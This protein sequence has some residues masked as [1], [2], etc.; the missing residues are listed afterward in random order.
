MLVISFHLP[1][2]PV[3]LGHLK[4][5]QTLEGGGG[6]ITSVDFDPSVSGLC[7]S[8]V[9]CPPLSTPGRRG[10]WHLREHRGCPRSRPWSSYPNP[11]WATSSS[12]CLLPWAVGSSEAAPAPALRPEGRC[13]W[14]G[15]GSGPL[16]S[17]PVSLGLPGIGSYLQ[18]GC[19]ALE[20]WGGAVQG[21]PCLGTQP[22][23]Q[24]SCLGTGGGVMGSWLCP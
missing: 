7:P 15:P 9:G 8:G 16:P 10:L 24:G 20:G 11:P 22:G 1:I 13:L 19:P 17:T 14:L 6:S 18:S 5:H 2:P 21:E 4:A 3:P 12:A 23:G